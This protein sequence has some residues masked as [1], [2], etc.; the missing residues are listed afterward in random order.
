MRLLSI[1]ATL[2]LLFPHSASADCV[3]DCACETCVTP[4]DELRAWEIARLEQ[5]LYRRVEYPSRM[6]TLNNEIEFTEA[7]IGRPGAAPDRL[8]AASRGS[9]RATP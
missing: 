9:V 7:R 2:A 5:R 1:V 6:R 3:G 8:R 4:A